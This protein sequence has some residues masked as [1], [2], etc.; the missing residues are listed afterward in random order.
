MHWDRMHD[1][2]KARAERQK[3]QKMH[4]GDGSA[5]VEECVGRDF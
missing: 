5:D 1:Q 3:G 2:L 4:Y